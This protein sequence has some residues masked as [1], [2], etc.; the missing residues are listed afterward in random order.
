MPEL[1]LPDCPFCGVQVEF[2]RDRRLTGHPLDGGRIL[3]HWQVKCDN[4]KCS[5]R[6]RT[7]GLHR[8]KTQALR[9]F[10]PCPKT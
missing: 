8:T 7:T 5:V 3:T 2:E 4:P 6:P 10:K 9:E 1:I